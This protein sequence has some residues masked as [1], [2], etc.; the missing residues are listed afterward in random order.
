MDGGRGLSCEVQR[1]NAV[2]AHIAKEAAA[3]RVW[4]YTGSPR[5][6]ATN[7]L[8]LL[9]DFYNPMFTSIYNPLAIS[10]NPIKE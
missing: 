10:K 7:E 4:K 1:R 3:A 8:Q 9:I 2:I 6:P 5:K